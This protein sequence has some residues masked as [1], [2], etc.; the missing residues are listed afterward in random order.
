LDTIF[1]TGSGDGEDPSLVRYY[2]FMF[3]IADAHSLP[4]L[5]LFSS[6][7]IVLQGTKISVTININP[8][9]EHELR[10]ESGVAMGMAV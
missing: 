1:I 10:A 8:S 4:F 9:K 5:F 3:E 6:R 7:R 2:I